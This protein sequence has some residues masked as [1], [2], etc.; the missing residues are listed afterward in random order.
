MALCLWYLFPALFCSRYNPSY[1]PLLLST[2]ASPVLDAGFPFLSLHHLIISFFLYCSGNV[3]STI[4]CLQCDGETG[5]VRLEVSADHGQS[6][7][8]PLKISALLTLYLPHR[9]YVPSVSR[10][11][12]FIHGSSFGS[13]CSMSTITYHP[14]WADYCILYSR[15]SADSSETSETARA[16]G[17]SSPRAHSAQSEYESRSRGYLG[18]PF[19]KR[20]C[21]YLAALLRLHTPQFHCC[22]AATLI[23]Q[24]PLLQPQLDFSVQS[25]IVRRAGLD[26]KC[27][28]ITTLLEQ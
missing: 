20:V 2:L 9:R 23:C 24:W 6:R 16:W 17:P 27:L 12:V 14:S 11:D 5:G 19:S 4:D 8:W 28:Q 15:M 18:A 10:F 21:S 3:S 26:F 25:V 13:C 1:H 7:T 22:S